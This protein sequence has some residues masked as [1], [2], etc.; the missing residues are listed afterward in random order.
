MNWT[1]LVYNNYVT[2]STEL[3]NKLKDHNIHQ[4]GKGK[5]FEGLNLRQTRQGVS[6]ELVLQA[7]L[8]TL[9]KQ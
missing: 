1:K 4:T 9:L 6:A 5:W 8:Q 2:K 3:G 7:K